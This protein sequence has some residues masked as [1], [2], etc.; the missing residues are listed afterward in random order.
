LE[1]NGYEVALPAMP[2]ADRP[3]IP[4][5]TGFIATL[6]GQPDEGTVLIGHSLGAQAVLHYLDALGNSG[7]SVGKTVLI[8]SNFPFGMS[9]ESADRRTGGD[10]AL[11]PWLMAG[12]EPKKVKKAAGRCTVILSDD[13]PYIPFREAKTSFETSLSPTI[14]VETGKGHFNED[15]HMVELPSALAAVLS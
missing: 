7:R 15:D 10:Q 8:A 2:H 9:L 5:W 4:E 11:R 6:V 14:I 12:A 13:D 3:T 1:R